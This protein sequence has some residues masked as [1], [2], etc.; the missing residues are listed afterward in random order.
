MFIFFMK[1]AKFSAKLSVASGS[2]KLRPLLMILPIQL[3]PLLKSF[4]KI[5][6]PPSDKFESAT[7]NVAVFFTWGKREI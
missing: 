4:P 1:N 6:E 2:W 3:W 7:A 5:A